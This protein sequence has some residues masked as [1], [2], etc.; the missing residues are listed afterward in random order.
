MVETHRSAHRKRNP[1][2][3]DGRRLDGLIQPCPLRAIAATRDRSAY[4]HEL[5][6]RLF[7]RTLTV[8]PVVPLSE[9]HSVFSGLSAADSWHL[10]DSGAYVLVVSDP[11]V[12]AP[13]VTG[14][15]V[16]AGADVLGI[17]ESRHSLEDVCLRLVNEDAEAGA[18]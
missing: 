9:P 11:A 7:S 1:R 17:T 10:D 6:E 3:R 12:A 4:G 5:R 15:L 13:E 2:N 18:E 8:G 14:A 16:G